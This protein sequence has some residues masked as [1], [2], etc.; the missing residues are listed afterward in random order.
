MNLV[1]VRYED[2]RE[3]NLDVS[4]VKTKK[5]WWLLPRRKG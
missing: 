3:E 5:M 2:G 1:K 4:R